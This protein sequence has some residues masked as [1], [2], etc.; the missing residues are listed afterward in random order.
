[1]ENDQLPAL[2]NGSYG[3][4]HRRRSA[5]HRTNAK[6]FP[7]GLNSSAAV[8]A[9]EPQEH[10]DITYNTVDEWLNAPQTGKG[11]LVEQLYQR[12]GW[13]QFV[14]VSSDPKALRKKFS[15]MSQRDL[16]TILV[17]LDRK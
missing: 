4:T 3:K 10:H 2:G 15:S 12:R 7:H 14:K 1:L 13:E 11:F 6:P 5:S 9:R 17:K 8:A 16:A